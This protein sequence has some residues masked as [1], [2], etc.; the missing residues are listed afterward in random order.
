MK[1][2]EAAV[3]IESTLQLELVLVLQEVI[4]FQKRAKTVQVCELSEDY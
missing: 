1:K 4:H 2:V 3:M